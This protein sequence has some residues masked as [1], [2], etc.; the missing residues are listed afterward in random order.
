MQRKSFRDNSH[1]TF[2][3]SANK[4]QKKAVRR[5]DEQRDRLKELSGRLV[6]VTGSAD[7]GHL[8]TVVAEL[9]ELN[10]AVS[11]VTQ[12]PPSA[13]DA[14]TSAQ[15]FRG[16]TAAY[17]NA[18]E[19]QAMED[20]SSSS[21]SE[22]ECYQ[23]VSPSSRKVST[24]SVAAPVPRQPAVNNIVAA[25]LEEAP[26][27]RLSV[28]QGKA[29]AKRGA[30]EL[31]EAARREAE[32]HGGDVVVAPCKCLDQCKKGP[33]VSVRA[34]GG[35]SAVILNGV[36]VERLPSIMQRTSADA[37]LAAH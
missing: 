32:A 10:H 8:A 3:A 2:Y 24:E 4:R 20:S 7:L 36:P 13:V 25:R 5:L 14:G 18:S 27:A 33:N 1:L 28:C 35:G 11:Q 9:Q 30:V 17:H 19:V 37:V 21:E 23:T 31:L 16:R 15:R 26:V 6:T 22:D 12:H 29:C 34:A